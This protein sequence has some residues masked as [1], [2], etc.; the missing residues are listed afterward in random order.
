MN[1]N[2]FTEK[3]AAESSL[4]IQNTEET[5]NENS[6]V[7]SVQNV[8][9]I[10]IHEAGIITPHPYGVFALCKIFELLQIN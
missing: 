6:T 5:G 7:S 4:N 10:I 3:N 9:N 2:Q 1:T 8:D